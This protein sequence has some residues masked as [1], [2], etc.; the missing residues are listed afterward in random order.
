MKTL[1]YILIGALSA[2]SFVSA[3]FSQA[4]GNTC[5][6]AVALTS[7]A[8][9]ATITTGSRTTC[10]TANNFAAGFSS[11]DATYGGSED[12][13]Y[14]MVVPAGGGNYTFSFTGP[15]AS[16]KILSIHSACPPTAANTLG[17]F[18]TGFLT[19]GTW[20]GNLPAGTVFIVIDT[21]SNCGVFT[22]NI[23]RN[24]APC[25]NNVNNPG[26]VSVPAAICVGAAASIS[27]VTAATGSPGSANYYFYYRGGPSNVPWQMYNGQTTN[28]SSTLPVEVI[29]TPGTWFIARNSAF[30]CGQ[31]N[32]ATTLDLQIIVNE[33]S[34][35]GTTSGTNSQICVNTSTGSINVSNYVGNIQRWEK[36]LDN[37]SWITIQNTS[38]SITDTPTLPG[39]W[40][41]RAVVLSGVCNESCS[42]IYSIN[43]IAP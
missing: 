43:V 31:T 33:A 29:N 42:T 17:G 8:V 37:G 25:D 7:P 3:S 12:G 2:F 35:G 14:S 15:G 23:K 19:G 11:V 36:K 4:P 10:G 27:N 30:G 32:N 5:A 26:A 24:A 16:F 21:D 38:N 34:N 1:Y 9:G 18:V 13:V 28:S 39:I 20:T 41:Y 40:Q 22:L 6:S